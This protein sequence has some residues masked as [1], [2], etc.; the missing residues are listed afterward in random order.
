MAIRAHV[1]IGG[2]IVGTAIAFELQARGAKVILI[3]RDADPQGASAFSF[4]SLSAMD[5]PF[6]DVYL[7]KGLGMVGWG[8][9][10][11]RWGR[12]LGVAR[13]GEIR[14]AETNDE[15]VHLRSLVLRATQRGYPVRTI[16]DKEIQQR[17]PASAPKNVLMASFAPEDGQ[18]DPLRAI[19]TL[20]TAFMESGGEFMVGKASLVF[21][22]GMKVR[23]EDA[24]I[25]PSRVVI[26]TGA[27]TASLLERFGW[28]VPMEPSPGLL[29]L[30]E[31]TEETI[32]G[33]VY[34]A[35]AGGTAIHLRQLHDGRLLVG[36]RTQDH[37]ARN[38]T[39]DHAM[40]LLYALRRSFPSLTGV[41]LDRFTVEW[42]PMPR[43]GMPIVGPVPGMSSVYMAAAHAG[44]TLAPVVAELAAGELIDGVPSPRLGAFRPSRFAQHRADA[45][46]SIEE[47][48]ED[49]PQVF[50]E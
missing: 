14:W 6:R 38:P 37:V 39:Q 23:I 13:D 11:R 45:Y 44:I 22:D 46:R 42:R 20:R 9:W 7:L 40:R 28:E 21:Q 27:E 25:E 4:A 10:Q 35:S 2:G 29:A 17:L 15:A 5:E 50:L 1:V 12:N 18:V 49:N 8:R 30:T 19:K 47:A 43:D 3:E 32:R 34:V 31:P 36:E 48:F 41:G 33:T 24:E 16:S 26:A